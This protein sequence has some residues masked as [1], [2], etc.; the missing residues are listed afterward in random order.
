MAEY[1]DENGRFSNDFIEELDSI[2]ETAKASSTNS[3]YCICATKTEIE[4][5]IK[6]I[7]IVELPIDFQHLPPGIIG[8]YH[9]IP[10]IEF[11]DRMEVDNV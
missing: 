11:P 10:I 6:Y 1:V 9:G 4:R 7:G 2:I 3:D 8:T 5:L